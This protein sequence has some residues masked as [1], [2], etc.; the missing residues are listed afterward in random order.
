MAGKPVSTANTKPYG[1]SVKYAPSLGSLL[2]PRRTS[3]LVSLADR[4][5]TRASGVSLTSA[6][7]DFIAPADRE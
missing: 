4:S 2:R 6:I 1:C 5:E 3:F 7:P